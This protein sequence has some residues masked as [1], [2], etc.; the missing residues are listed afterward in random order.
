VSVE[1][2]QLVDQAIKL[3]KRMKDD[4]KL[5]DEIKSQLQAVA[6]AEMDNKNIKFKQIFGSIG[7]FSTTFK[8]KFEIDDYIKLVS[9]LGEVANAKIVR[10]VEVKYDVESR[11]KEALI[12]LYKD[13][14]SSEL[15]VEDV[16][17]GLGLGDKTV[18]MA[19]KK[20]KGDYLKDKRILE[21][22]G[23]TGECEEELDAI[24]RYRNWETVDHFFSSLT[25]EQITQLKKTIFIEEQLA[26][27]LEYDK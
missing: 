6:F 20:L 1:L 17:R 10:K 5:L 24:R 9:L 21:S 11:F 12:A 3:D 4:K 2:A 13:D 7:H 25:T 16:L 23:V 14:F 15:T 18:K 19:K 26:A 22:L 27:G 8:E